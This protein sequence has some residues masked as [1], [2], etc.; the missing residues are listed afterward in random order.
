MPTEE[1]YTWNRLFEL[2]EL[3][4]MFAKRQVLALKIDGK[5]VCLG[6][7]DGEYYAI[8]DTCPHAGASLGKGWCDEAGHVVCP[9]HRIKFD[10]RTGKNT[11]GEGYRVP[12]YP[13]MVK[14]D[15]LYIGFSNKKWWKFWE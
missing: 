15:T 11:T 5:P 2:W 4:Q 14:E 8:H 12:T 9:I 10:M 13:L 7:V 6:K 1:N 3:E